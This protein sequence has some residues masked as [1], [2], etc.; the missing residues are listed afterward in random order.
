MKMRTGTEFAEKP[1]KQ[2][3]SVTKGFQMT[4]SLKLSLT[5]A[6]SVALLTACG[7]PS[8]T[9]LNSGNG[10][11]STPTP[12]PTT[13]PPSASASFAITMDAG[14]TA[15]SLELRESK[16]VT[17]T[18]QGFNGFSGVVTVT[19]AGLPAGVTTDVPSQAL[20]VPLNGT[21]SS[22]F[23]LK[24]DST[25]IGAGDYAITLG[26]TAAGSLTGSANVALT[27]KPVITLQ[28]L[29]SFPVAGAFNFWDK[30]TDP[31]NFVDGTVIHMGNATTVTV[32]WQKMFSFNAADTTTGHRIH[33]NG[34]AATGSPLV[35][36]AGMNL[37]NDGALEHSSGS[38]T[39]LDNVSSE[40][41]TG[42]ESGTA[43]VFVRILKPTAAT[44]KT[45]V[46]Y[47]DH[48]NGDANKTITSKSGRLTIY[49]P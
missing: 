32:Q 10:S 20:T 27:V 18:V 48:Q 14:S 28:S 46:D 19:P 29:A 41:L 37:D 26:G 44:A 33:G 35:K 6:A 39:L 34:T 24:T 42:A 7:A 12:D 30:T 13:T 45:V 38:T 2:V 36:I 16:D 31:V 1:I 47:Y 9:D 3:P 21:A 8:V 15:P 25:V 43:H 5:L 23:T 4:G 49:Q 11:Q 40:D 22:K 17:F